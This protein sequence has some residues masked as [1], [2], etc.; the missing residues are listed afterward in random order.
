M[1]IHIYLLQ[2][3]KPR[4]GKII[5]LYLFE[6]K[7]PRHEFFTFF[8]VLI[9]IREW[10]DIVLKYIYFIEEINSSQ[11]NLYCLFLI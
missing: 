9:Y 8:L 6:E 11:E 4:R 7:L 3:R 2:D 10:H 5:L 1:Y